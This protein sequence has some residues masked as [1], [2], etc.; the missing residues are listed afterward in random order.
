ME[1]KV[2]Y[3]TYNVWRISPLIILVKKPI[4]FFCAV[5][6]GPKGGREF[7]FTTNVKYN[8]ANSSIGI[9][10]IWTAG[11]GPRFDLKFK[12][13]PISLWAS[14]LYEPR[15]DVAGGM[16]GIVGRFGPKKKY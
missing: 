14:A 9:M 15:N 16:F 7:W 3:E 4:S 8:F 10:G 5:E 13:A 6:Y 2:G 11:Y 12:K 1:F